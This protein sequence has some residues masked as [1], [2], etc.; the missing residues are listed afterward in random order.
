MLWYCRIVILFAIQI[1]IKVSGT[2]HGYDNKDFDQ[3]KRNHS[4][5]D[6][7]IEEDPLIKHLM[8]ITTCWTCIYS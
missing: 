1:K 4:F 5:N 3:Q 8:K 7:W 6:I 2:S